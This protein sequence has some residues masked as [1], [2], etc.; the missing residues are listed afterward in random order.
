MN[1]SEDIC[2]YL[3]REYGEES[4]FPEA[5]VTTTTITGWMPT[6]LRAGRGMTRYANADVNAATRTKVTQPKVTLYN[7]EGEPV[8]A[9]SARALVR[10]GGALRARERGKGARRADARRHRR[11]QRPVPYLVDENTGVSR[12]GSRKRSS[13]T[14]SRRTGYVDGGAESVTPPLVAALFIPTRVTR[15]TVSTKTRHSAICRLHR[16]TRADASNK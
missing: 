10:T 11:G 9:F 3:W 16:R 14:C 7:Y 8:R 5:I 13:S 2:R 1:E 6:L 15:V 12:W 4:A